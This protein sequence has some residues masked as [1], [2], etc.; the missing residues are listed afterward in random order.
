MLNTETYKKIT[1]FYMDWATME[2]KRQLTQPKV[3]QRKQFE[4]M[5]SDIM[6]SKGAVDPEMKQAGSET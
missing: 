4:K 3:M 6:K 2:H 5:K 1:L